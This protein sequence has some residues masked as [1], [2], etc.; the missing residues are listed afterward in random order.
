MPKRIIILNKYWITRCSNSVAPI[1]K[2]VQNIGGDKINLIGLVP[3][4]VNSRTFELVSSDAIKINDV[5]LVI[6]MDLNF[7]N[8]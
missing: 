6:L 5:D 4:G 3:E 8:T 2:I 1:T 7:A